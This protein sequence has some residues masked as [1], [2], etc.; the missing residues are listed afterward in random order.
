MSEFRSVLATATNNDFTFMQLNDEVSTI[1]G[2]VFTGWDSSP[3]AASS[4]IVGI[5]HP[6][7]DLKK[8]SQGT[9]MGFADFGGIVTGTGS[10]LLVLWSEG[11]AEPG[12][13]GAGL[14]DPS[15][16]LR[17]TLTGGASS[18]RRICSRARIR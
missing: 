17:G 2:V 11:I 12:S 14:F 18:A 16:R 9:H 3:L 1:A 13:S 5:H 15:D 8:W 7:G 10:H 6:K 4:S